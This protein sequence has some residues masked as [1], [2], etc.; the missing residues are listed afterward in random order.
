MYADFN[1]IY[2][3]LQYVWC[4]KVKLRLP[5]HLYSVI[6]LPSKT[7]ILLQISNNI[8]EYVTSAQNSLVLIPYL[9][10][11]SQQCFVKTL[12]RHIVFMRTVFCFNAFQCFGPSLRF[13]VRPTSCSQSRS[14]KLL[15]HEFERISW[16]HDELASR[17]WIANSTHAIDDFSSKNNFRSL[18]AYFRRCGAQLVF[19]CFALRWNTNVY[20]VQCRPTVL[21]L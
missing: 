5:P 16:Q 15:Y 14:Q 7:H 10:T 9:L 2:C 21:L 19:A 11:Y 4:T 17:T 1:H 6:P 3:L 8:F 13:L 18:L 20:S 12:L